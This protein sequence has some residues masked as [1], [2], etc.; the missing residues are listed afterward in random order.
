MAIIN[1]TPDSFSGDGLAR[2]A[3][4]AVAAGL[5]AA[6]NGADL[7]DV[8]GESTRPGNNPVDVAEELDRVMP[9]V[10]QLVRQTSLPVSVDTAKPRVAAEALAAGARVLNDVSGLALSDELGRHA[11]TAGA[12]LV[13]MRFPGYPRNRPRARRPDEGDLIDLIGSDLAASAGRAL[14]AGVAPEAIV[15]DPGFGF[16]LLAPDSIELLRRLG[17]LRGIGYPLLA[18]VSR[19]GFTGQPEQLAVGERQWGTAAA[20]ALAI[21]NGAAILRVHDVPA[22]RRVAR[23]TDLV[24][25]AEVPPDA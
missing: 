4:A 24:V 22:A 6:A 8:G 7:L 19:K 10:R 16:G 12:G 1:V 21:A 17:E 3:G 20:Q 25:H 5:Q 11:A 23:F 13:L 14:A 18:G 2:D 15:L 9:V